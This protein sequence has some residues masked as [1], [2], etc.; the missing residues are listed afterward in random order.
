M[1]VVFVSNYMNHHQVE[2]SLE[3]DKRVEYACV[4][5]VKNISENAYDTIHDVW[6][7]KNAVSNLLEVINQTNNKQKLTINK[8]NP[9]E[10]INE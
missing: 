3:F 6:C 2:V 4:N 8:N 1:R 5:D 9:C 10:L 7:A